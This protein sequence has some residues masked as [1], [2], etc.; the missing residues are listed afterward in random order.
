MVLATHY[1]CN[2]VISLAAEY[3]FKYLTPQGTFLLLGLTT[4]YSCFFIKHYMPETKG[5]TDKEKK[6]LYLPKAYQTV[7][8]VRV[9][10]ALEPEIELE[11]TQTDQTMG[12]NYD[13]LT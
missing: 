6:Q 10:T 2:I 8:K 9:V 13:E 5:L 7:S 1:T 12:E 11:V 4:L 3:L